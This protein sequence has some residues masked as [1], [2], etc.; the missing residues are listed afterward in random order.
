MAFG[1]SQPAF[2]QPTWRASQQSPW[3]QSSVRMPESLPGVIPAAPVM[4]PEPVTQASVPQQS[5]FGFPPLNMPMIPFMPS[6]LGG[7]SADQAPAGGG[8]FGGGVWIDPASG[9]RYNYLGGAGPT[10]MGPFAFP[11]STPVNYGGDYEG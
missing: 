8:G 2:S 6:V 5:G 9:K 7:G 11:Y 10:S 3:R 4:L 1:F